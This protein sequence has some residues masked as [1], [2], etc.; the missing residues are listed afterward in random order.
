MIH[1]FFKSFKAIR[2]H[3]REN[4]GKFLTDL[5]IK[6]IEDKKNDENLISYAINRLALYGDVENMK[7]LNTAIVEVGLIQSIERLQ[8]IVMYLHA[9]AIHK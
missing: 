3:D 7:R 5:V 6:K 2:Y 4:I 1:S 8:N 9:L